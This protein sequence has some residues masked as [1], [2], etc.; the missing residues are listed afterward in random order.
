[1]GLASLCGGVYKEPRFLMQR[2]HTW[3]TFCRIANAATRIGYREK[4]VS[5]TESEGAHLE[6]LMEVKTLSLDD[7]DSC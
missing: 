1:M 2:G 4:Y 7:A 3:D 5:C 6:Q